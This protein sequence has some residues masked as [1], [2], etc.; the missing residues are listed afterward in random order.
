MDCSQYDSVLPNIFDVIF[1]VSV[2]IKKA[3]TLLLL[4]VICKKL[5]K[6][7]KLINDWNSEAL[8]SSLTTSERLLVKQKKIGGQ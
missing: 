2:L 5:H 8:V 6:S 3:A 4:A 7:L 1:I